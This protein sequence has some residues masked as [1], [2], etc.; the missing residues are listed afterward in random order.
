MQ[1]TFFYLMYSG[2][3]RCALKAPMR[4]EGSY[5]GAMRFLRCTIA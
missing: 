2:V 4:A 1:V 3:T 5:T